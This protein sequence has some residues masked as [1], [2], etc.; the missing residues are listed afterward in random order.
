MTYENYVTFAKQWET[1]SSGAHLNAYA[2]LIGDEIAK[3]KSGQ[4]STPIT[5]SGKAEKG[6]GKA[7]KDLT[8][9]GKR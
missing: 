7:E 8:K 4:H 9:M 6:K 2:K 1:N 5:R 3:V